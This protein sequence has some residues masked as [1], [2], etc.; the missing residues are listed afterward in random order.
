M[1]SALLTSGSCFWVDS[2]VFDDVEACCAR[3]CGSC[4]L[5]FG[6]WALACDAGLRLHELGICLP[7][8]HAQ[9]ECF[10]YLVLSPLR[11][12]FVL[13]CSSL[14]LSN[15]L[16]IH[17]TRLAFLLTTHSPCLSSRASFLFRFASRRLP[18][19]LYVP[20]DFSCLPGAFTSNTSSVGRRRYC[21]THPRLV[22]QD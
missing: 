16:S 7:V 12:V 10:I 9:F 18:L 21:R 2:R 14:D 20:S 13:F 1:N 3:F 22:R 15:S 19:R 11:C 4:L 5:F 17:S 8:Q 6:S